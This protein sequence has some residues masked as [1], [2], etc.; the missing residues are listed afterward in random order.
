MNTARFESLE[1][2]QMMSVALNTNLVVN[3]DAETVIAPPPVPVPAAVPLPPNGIQGWEV[4][5]AFELVRYGDRGMPGVASPGPAA[6][7]AMP[8]GGG[9]SLLASNVPASSAAQQEIDISSI[10]ADVDAGRINFDFSAF[11]GG[12]GFEKDSIKAT[13]WFIDPKVEQVP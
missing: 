13:L 9:Q 6:P 10:A 5:G 2:R 1:S 7:C 12:F 3:G 8:F 4:S 11:L